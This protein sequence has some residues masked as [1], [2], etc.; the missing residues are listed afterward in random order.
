VAAGSD[1]PSVPYGLG[2][3]AELSVLSAA[4]LPSDQ[5][6]RLVTAEA[7]LALGLERELGTVEAGK[8]ADLVVIDGNPLMNLRDSLRIVAVVKDGVWIQRSE[9]LNPPRD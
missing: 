9:L 5:A 2:L 6:L 8:L 7:A 1:A 4:G 3:H